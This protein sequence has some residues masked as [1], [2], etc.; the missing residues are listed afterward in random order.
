MQDDRLA[1]QIEFIVEID[2]LK[3]IERQTVL[4]DR[5]RQENAAEHSWHLAVMVLLLSEY[6]SEDI[7]LLKVLK[8]AL[9]HDIVEV[10]AGDTFVYDDDGHEDKA[11]RERQAAERLF[12]MLPDDQ[13]RA[14]RALWEEFE[15][16]E[17]PE[18]K[19]AAALDRLQP[20]LHNYRTQGF[21]WQKHGITLDQ[22]IARNRH[23]AEGTPALWNYAYAMIQDAVKQG[24]LA[25]EP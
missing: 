25:A 18:A 3:R 2:K 20:L 21:A 5:S 7:D 22:V 23:M 17:T 19:F 10:D 12:G 6:A 14:F 24:Y 4:I 15:A 8:M 11:G 9:L 16:R 13:K 1:R